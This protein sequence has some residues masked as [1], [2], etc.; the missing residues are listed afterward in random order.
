MASITPL[1]RLFSPLP[2][3]RRHYADYFSAISCH[4]ATAFVSAASQ[5]GFLPPQLYDFASFQP[6]ISPAT[7]AWFQFDSSRMPYGFRHF[8]FSS[9]RRI[10]QLSPLA[11]DDSLS[12]RL[13]PLIARRLSEAF[14]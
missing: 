3:F 14:S 13:L 4:Y 1:R 8:R 2:P 6:A 9:C 12:Q 10:S 11:F 5:I 7:P